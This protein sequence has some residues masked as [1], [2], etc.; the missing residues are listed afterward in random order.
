MDSI[1]LEKKAVAKIAEKS[2]AII[3]GLLR[4]VRLYQK[5]EEER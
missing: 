4:E 3:A 2:D 5:N 1:A